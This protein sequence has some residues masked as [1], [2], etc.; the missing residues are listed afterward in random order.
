MGAQGKI[1]K[2]SEVC[3][4]VTTEK[5]M[6]LIRDRKDGKGLDVKP[7]NGNKRGWLCLD[8]VTANAYQ[9]VFNNVKA[10]LKDKLDNLPVKKAVSIVWSAIHK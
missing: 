8:I 6:L 4:K 3:Q 9:T 7:Y 10:E 5:T 1:M 2:L